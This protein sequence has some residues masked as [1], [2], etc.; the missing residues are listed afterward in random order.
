M[1][2]LFNILTH[3]LLLFSLG[4]YLILN[5]QWYSYKLNRVILH[6]HNP[7]QHIIFF[8][9]PLFAYFA[10]KQYVFIFL[11][12]YILALYFW[13]RKLDKKL[14]FTGRVKRFFGLLLFWALFL[15]ILC[16][17]KFECQIFPT[18]LPL[19]LALIVSNFIEKFLFTMYKNEAKKK[20]DAINPTII[21]VTASYG[22]TSIKNFLNQILSSKYKTYATPRSVNTLAGILKDIN[23][24]LPKDSEIYIVEAGAR[25]RGDIYEISSFLNPEYVVVGK[26]GAQHIEYFKTIEN[27]IATKLEIISSKRLKKAFLYYEIPVKDRDIFIKFGQNI[28]N[29]KSSLDGIS[30]DLEINKKVYHFEAPILGGFNALNITAAIMV[31]Y[32]LGIDIK[33]IKKAVSNLKPVEHRLQKIEVNGKIVIDDSFNGNLEGMISSYE[34]VKEHKGRKVLVTPGIVESTKEANEKLAKKIDE[35]FDLVII[36]GKINRDVLDKNINKA[37]KIILYDKSKL[38]EVLAENTKAGDLILFSNDAPAFM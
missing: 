30:F 38:Q 9:L 25:E 29:V 27:I 36:T 33:D 1:E 31:A 32:E 13:Q 3:F 17:A 28:K 11:I 34:L 7:Y 37:K 23:E 21:G 15:D 12:F 16:L 5:L 19:A 35:V 10:L 4:Y 24:D 6:H 26:I 18:I 20:L 22:K 8:L 14:V 2:A